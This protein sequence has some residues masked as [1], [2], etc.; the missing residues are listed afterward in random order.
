MKIMIRHALTGNVILSEVVELADWH[1]FTTDF[2]GFATYSADGR[3]WMHEFVFLIVEHGL[4]RGDDKLTDIP[5]IVDNLVLKRIGERICAHCDRGNPATE[6]IFGDSAN[7]YQCTACWE[8]NET[9]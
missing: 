2:L 1:E 6:R 3:L 9:V 4:L 5:K 7:G 8:E